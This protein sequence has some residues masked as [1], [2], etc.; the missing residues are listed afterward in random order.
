MTPP[1]RTEVALPDAHPLSYV[2]LRFRG[3]FTARQVLDRPPSVDH[4]EVETN[5]REGDLGVRP[6]DPDLRLRRFRSG[7]DTD[8]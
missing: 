4:A 6:V 8:G 7:R 3:Q 1:S 2:S 5:V